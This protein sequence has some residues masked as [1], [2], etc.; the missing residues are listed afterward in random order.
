MILGA[1]SPIRNKNSGKNI[2]ESCLENSRDI[3]TEVVVQNNRDLELKEY[4]IFEELF[5][6]AKKLGY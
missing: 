4:K 2:L 1:D 3:V 6:D 5:K